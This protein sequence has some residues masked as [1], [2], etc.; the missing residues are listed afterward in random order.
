MEATLFLQNKLARHISWNGQMLTFTRYSKNEYEELTDE[1]ERTFT[2]KGLFH[3]G[4]GYGGMLKIEIYERDGGRTFTKF[5]PLVL[6]LYEDGKDIQTD[7]VVEIGGNK[8]NVV[9]ITNVKNLNIA[10]EIS[11][12]IDNGK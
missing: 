8:Y 12:E 3:D 10:F 7:D 9:D 4:G 5:K 1:V 2:F 11:L 6:C